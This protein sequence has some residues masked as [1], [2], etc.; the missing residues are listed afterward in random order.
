MR[1]IVMFG[2]VGV[3]AVTG[4][5]CSMFRGSSDEPSATPPSA[6]APTSASDPASASVPATSGVPSAPDS[7]T[8]AASSSASPTPADPSQPGAGTD[9]L[10]TPVATRT[11]AIGGKKA[12]LTVYPVLRDGTTSHMNFTIAGV[13]AGD[14][15][16]VASSLSDGNY[17]AIDFNGDAADGIQLVD[18]KNSKLYLVAS[19]GAGQCLCSHDLS[20]V[21]LQPG[22]PVVFSATFA[23]PPADVSAVDVRI[24]TFGTVKS[25]PVS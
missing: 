24:P 9:Q 23:A 11:S 2:V 15:V 8:A 12:V 25:V 5:G 22:A 21:F 19:D 1:K 3:L 7:P 13:T 16:Q 18:G 4:T 10:G 20:G 14:R 17:K 6:V